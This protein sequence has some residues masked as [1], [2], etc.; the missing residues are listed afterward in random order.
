MFN[1][2]KGNKSKSS[3]NNS[4]MEPPA[5]RRVN[6]DKYIVDDFDVK[7]VSLEKYKKE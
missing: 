7:S 3:S 6:L 1:R 4:T 5:P 2:N